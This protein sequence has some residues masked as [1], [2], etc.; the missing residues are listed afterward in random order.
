LSQSSS[1]F[2]HCLTSN[3]FHTLVDGSWI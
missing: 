3:K 2:P 1:D